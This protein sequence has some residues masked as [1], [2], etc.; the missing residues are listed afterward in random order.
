MSPNP[1]QRAV[2]MVTLAQ[3]SSRGFWNVEFMPTL[4]IGPG[5]FVL[6]LV[7]TE[8]IL[9]QTPIFTRSIR[10]Q[11]GPSRMVIKPFP[12]LNYGL[13]D[14]AGLHYSSPRLRSAPPK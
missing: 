11:D 2:I 5:I 12:N 1:R 3:P 13:T 14:L 4:D 7:P 6:S 8:V 10:I 9:T